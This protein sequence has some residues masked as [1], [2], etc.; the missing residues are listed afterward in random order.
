MFN[1][2]F[3]GDLINTKYPQIPYGF[4]T[5][6]IPMI[7]YI[8]S[9]FEPCHDKTNIVGFA[10]S[11]DPDQPAHPCCLLTNPITSGETDS[12]QDGS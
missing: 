4:N 11:M 8:F 3:L 2:Y 1:A 5:Y 6:L 12:E 7:Q 10:T 9:T